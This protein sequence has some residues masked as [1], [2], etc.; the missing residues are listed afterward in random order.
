MIKFKCKKCGECCIDIPLTEKEI[1]M[2][3]YILNIL[4]REN[5]D[6]RIIEYNRHGLKYKLVGKCPF[7]M[8]NNLCEIYE[9]RPYVCSV[10]PIADNCI[11]W[12]K[13]NSK[14]EE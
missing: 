5:I 9:F 8:K 2:F 7:L 4:K 1:A 11:G 3:K 14:R 6:D 13:D 10:F 12:R